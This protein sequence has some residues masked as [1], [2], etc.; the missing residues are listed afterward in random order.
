MA[1]K[2]EKSS[3][4][5]KERNDGFIYVLISRLTIKPAFS[6]YHIW[7]I[8]WGIDMKRKYSIYDSYGYLIRGNFN[9]YRAA[10]TFK[11]V[12]N[13]LDWTIKWKDSRLYLKECYYG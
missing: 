6:L 11:I 3:T 9:S 8:K 1:K 10:Y 5:I 12:M 7:Y 4:N 13:R 2:Q